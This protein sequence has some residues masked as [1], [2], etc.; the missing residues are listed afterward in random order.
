MTD[1]LVPCIQGVS[2]Y[3]VKVRAM[4]AGSA[5][6]LVKMMDGHYGCGITVAR[7]QEEDELRSLLN[8]TSGERPQY[9][10]NPNN[11]P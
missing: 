6:E 10:T 1:Y 7:A 4:D 8:D 9:T 11:Q 2:L 5:T 3:F